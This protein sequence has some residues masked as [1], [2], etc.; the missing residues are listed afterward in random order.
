[1]ITLLNQE[2]RKIVENPEVARRL[3]ELGGEP[4]SSLPGEM[5]RYVE[6]EYRKWQKLIELRKIERQ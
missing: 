4:R 6:Q 2:M 5:Q 3:V 1:M